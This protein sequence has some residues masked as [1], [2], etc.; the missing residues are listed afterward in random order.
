M[1][2]VF[3]VK[4]VEKGMENRAWM[5]REGS[6]WGEGGQGGGKERGRRRESLKN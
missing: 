4:E 5:G 6:R 1:F 3:L 2:I